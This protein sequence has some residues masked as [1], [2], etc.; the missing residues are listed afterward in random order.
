[1]SFWE[2]QAVRRI[3]QRWR[4][5]SLLKLAT[6]E[7]HRHCASVATSF[8]SARALLS[9][10]ELHA[11][12]LRC[13]PCDKGQHPNRLYNSVLH[14][15]GSVLISS[16]QGTWLL[17][18]ADVGAWPGT[19]SAPVLCLLPLLCRW[20]RQVVQHLAA[21][22]EVAEAYQQKHAC[23]AAF[24]VRLRLSLVQSCVTRLASCRPVPA[25][26]GVAAPQ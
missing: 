13:W 15:P 25:A 17:L 16:M 21:A 22:E 6:A 10:S 26:S 9:A 11:D 2:G 7:Q 1:M 24:Q 23:R 12:M 20:W 8:R 18:L 14:G 19:N 3:F 4:R 5:L